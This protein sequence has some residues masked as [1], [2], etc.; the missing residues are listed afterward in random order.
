[1]PTSAYTRSLIGGTQIIEYAGNDG[2]P[3]AI[4]E[5]ITIND[6]NIHHNNKKLSEIIELLLKRVEN[7][8]K[9]YEVVID[10]ELERIA[11]DNSSER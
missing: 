2:I 1:M 10:K 8:E 7:L 9:L 4:T 6:N 5:D 11:N 3:I